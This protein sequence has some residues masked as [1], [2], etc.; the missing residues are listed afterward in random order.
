MV[1]LR[2]VMAVW[3]LGCLLVVQARAANESTIDTDAHLARLIEQLV[4]LRPDAR[5]GAEV[6]LLHLD[7]ASLDVVRALAEA[8]R[9]RDRSIAQRAGEVLEKL[10]VRISASAPQRRDTG[11]QAFDQGEYADMARAYRPLALIGFQDA[12]QLGHAHQLAAQWG[13]AAGAYRLA[14]DLMELRIGTGDDERPISRSKKLLKRLTVR[15]VT[16]DSDDEQPGDERNGL[17]EVGMGR[18]RGRRNVRAQR[19]ADVL[20]LRP[21]RIA[22]IVLTGRIEQHQLGDLEAAAATYRRCLR[23]NHLLTAP[24]EQ[25]AGDWQARIGV[26]LAQGRLDRLSLPSHERSELR[27]AVYALPE[28]AR[29]QEQLGK[30]AAAMQTWTRLHLTSMLYEPSGGSA[31]RIDALAPLAQEHPQAIDAAPVILLNEQEP[32]R[33]LDLTDPQ[34]L[35]AAYGVSLNGPYWNF[36]LAPLA[37]KQFATLTLD[38]DI[39]QIKPR[40]G[41]HCDVWALAGGDAARRVN[42]GGVGWPADQPGRQVVSRTMDVPPGVDAVHM[43]AGSW[44]GAFNVHSVAVAATFRLRDDEEAGATPV[45]WIQNEC[46]PKGGQLIANGNNLRNDVAQSN[47]T[48]GPY[49]YEYRH[50]ERER[51]IRREVLLQPG[52]RYGLFI[53]LDSP[54]DWRLTDLRG[55]GHL[56]GSDASLARLADGRWI[57]AWPA[58]AIRVATSEDLIDWKPLPDLPDAGLYGTQFNCHHPSIFVDRDG[59]I[60][61]AYFS[62]RLDV[63][64]LSTAGYRMYLCHSRD[65]RTWSSPRPIGPEQLGGWPAGT[66]SMR[67][68]PDGHVWLFWRGQ[69]ARGRTPDQISQFEPLPAPLTVRQR[70]HAWN[71]SASFDDAGRLHLVWNDFSK[72]LRYVRREPDGTWT[73]PLNLLD[74]QAS[75]YAKHPHLLTR[76]D[77]VALIYSNNQGAYLLGGKLVN[78]EPEFNEPI[79]IANHVVPRWN[80]TMHLTDNGQAIL[81]CGDDTVWLLR[82]SLDDLLNPPKPPDN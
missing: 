59:V 48:P 56:Y 19:D 11:K 77:R 63:D 44:K 43:R 8:E 1:K 16:P 23:Y 70:Q 71:P 38:C 73:A 31:R 21:R 45:L 6:A 66:I 24:I 81:M 12:I 3:A 69:Y 17:R 46:L 61:L 64:R 25:V 33:R 82:A 40:H 37:G 28:L 60:W 72:G 32:K 27:Y 49:V 68:G 26:L 14:L 79:K 65:G 30:T 41:G 15:K 5:R 67:A 35:S 50:P 22:L 7:T 39:E 80:R 47:L 74:P 10:A 2:R 58:G 9:H 76:G 75:Q 4:D 53:N 29:V 62:N 51:V 18:R 57:A 55:P 42:I 20:R 36:L 78:G 52:A 54:F 34:T 13:D